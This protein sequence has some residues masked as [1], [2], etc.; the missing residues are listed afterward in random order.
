MTASIAKGVLNQD[1]IKNELR[2]FIKVKVKKITLLVCVI[3]V[4]SFVS[5]VFAS[6]SA[7]DLPAER[8]EDLEETRI[9]LKKPLTV[10]EAEQ[11]ILTHQ[12]GQFIT[13]INYDMANSDFS[14]GVA[15]I[16]GIRYS[17]QKAIE[18]LESDLSYVEEGIANNSDRSSVWKGLRG[19]LQNKKDTFE[20][21]NLKISGFVLES[22]PEMLSKL[23]QDAN[24]S[25]DFIGI[26]W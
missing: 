5:V 2:R 23:K 20:N 12:I 25:L 17:F 18:K 4:I 24:I 11:F 16:K 10:S 13:E 8:S 21:E 9:F 26:D 22:T 3:V 19:V 15:Y 7:N 1:Y 6:L 14:G